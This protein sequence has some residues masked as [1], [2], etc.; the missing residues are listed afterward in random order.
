MNA[1]INKNCNKIHKDDIRMFW[2]TMKLFV[3][4]K[5]TGNDECQMLNI[6]GTVC[7]DSD[8]I[9]EEFNSYFSNVVRNICKEIPLEYDDCLKDIFSHHESHESVSRI[10]VKIFPQNSFDFNEVSEDHILK[11]L[12]PLTRWYQV[13]G[14]W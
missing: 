6:N 1:Y 7:N 3:H 4:D 11:F 13:V 10:K 9:A 8:I 2:N 5:S 12:K 14:I